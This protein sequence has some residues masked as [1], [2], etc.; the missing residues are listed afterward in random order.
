M[1]FI[2]VNKH[3]KFMSRCFKLAKLGEGKVSPNPMVGAVLVKKGKIIGEG[4]HKQRGEPHAEVNAIYNAA[5]NVQG[6]VLYCNLEPCCHTNKLTPPCV[7]LIIQNGISKVVISNLDPNLHVNGSGVREL[8]E[9]GIEVITGVERKK[10]KDLNKFYF[11]YAVNK[12]PYILIKIAQSLNG[13]ISEGKDKQT[14][15]TGKEGIKYVHK[16]RSTYDAVLVGA[17]TIAVDDPLLNTREVEGRNPVRVI[18]DGQLS[19]S[20]EAKVMTSEDPEK[21]WIFTSEGADRR[22]IKLLNTKG[23]KV[24]TIKA[25]DNNRIDLHEVLKI[26]GKEKITSVLVEGGQNIFSQFLS[27]YIFDE[28]MIL[29]TPKILGKGIDAANL[30]GFKGLKLQGYKKLGEDMMLLYSPKV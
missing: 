9:A 7:P 12:T 3:K 27:Q 10:G 13:K 11:K 20:P 2:D 1:N 26:L 25:A 6:A 4:W 18:I 8:K 19:I 14:W 22:K 5:D 17:N 30:T 28:L 15:L 29:L 16:L 23:S 24:F 21:T